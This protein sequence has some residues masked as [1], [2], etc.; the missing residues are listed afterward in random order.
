M[1]PLTSRWLT[2]WSIGLLAVLAASDASAQLRHLILITVDTLRA[3]RL[4]AYGYTEAHTPA[5]D[6]LAGESLRFER[7]YAHSSITFPSVASLLT[8]MLPAQHGIS[9]NRG[10]LRRTI[11]TIAT[12]LRSAGF[13]NAAFIGNYALRPSRKLDRGFHRYTSQF[14]GEEAVRGHPENPGP[15]LTYQALEWLRKRSPD[16]RIFLWVHYQEPHGPYTPPDFTAPKLPADTLELPESASNSGRNAIPRYQWLGHGRVAEY[17]VRYDAEIRAVD[18]EVG[19]LLAALRER[20]L[21]EES[22][23][24]FT[25][26]HGEAFGEDDLYCAHGEGLGEILLHVPLLLRLPG[27]T[28][29]V[30]AEAVRLIDV[31]PTALEL[32][33]VEATGLPGRSLLEDVGDRQ[34][35]AEVQDQR[36]TSWRSVREG[37]VELR[38]QQGGESRLLTRTRPPSDTAAEAERQRLQSALERLAPWPQS[39]PPTSELSPEERRALEALGYLDEPD[40]G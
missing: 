16:E 22:A 6:A 3:D 29:A 39:A 1:R 27:A 32:L 4:G 10:M 37:P 40:P 9:T 7:A 11:P 13:K 14:A 35:V 20:A 34:V 36:P 15:E 33:G 21:L 8:G 26:D 19:R 38:E 25:A 23:V 18:R 12:R 5:I 17:Q 24:V 2:H 30:R 31:A 28:P